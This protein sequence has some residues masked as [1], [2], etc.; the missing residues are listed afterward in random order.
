MDLPEPTDQPDLAPAGQVEEFR[1]SLL[2]F[3]PDVRAAAGPEPHTA[4]G[5]RPEPPAGAGGPEG[6]AVNYHFPVEVVLVGSLPDAEVARV[7]GHVFD[8][9]NRELAAR[10]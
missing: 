8:Q 3:A 9:L 2:D 6:P 1:R 5:I 4:G 10:L 7:A